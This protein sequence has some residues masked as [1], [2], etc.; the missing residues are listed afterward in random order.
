MPLKST[1]EWKTER[2]CA[3]KL[4]RKAFIPKRKNQNYCEEI[5]RKLAWNEAR[6]SVRIP[7]GR[8]KRLEREAAKLERGFQSY[9]DMVRKLLTPP[10]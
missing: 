7:H 4:C 10:R 2:I 1:D 3:R 6:V 5:C 9:R 8:I